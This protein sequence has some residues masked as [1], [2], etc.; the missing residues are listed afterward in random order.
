[1]EK[2]IIQGT[3][4]GRRTRGR[5]KIS[6]MKN[7]KTWTGL[8]TWM[9]LRAADDK[10]TMEIGCP[11]CDQPSDRRRQGKARHV[12]YSSSRQWWRLIAVVKQRHND[13]ITPFWMELVVDTTWPIILKASQLLW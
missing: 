8:V 5:S 12:W 4:P 10:F 3:L 7:I 2:E 6:W 11:W 9:L 13:T 1:L